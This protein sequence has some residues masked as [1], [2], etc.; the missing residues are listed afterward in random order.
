MKAALDDEVSKVHAK[1]TS[2]N[3][4]IATHLG[5]LEDAKNSERLMR[6]RADTAIRSDLEAKIK[7]IK[8]ASVLKSMKT[9]EEQALQI[10]QLENQMSM[11]WHHLEQAKSATE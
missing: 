2:W 7:E 5:D 10:A 6:E 8:Q 9:D 11:M 4:K 3:A 1:M